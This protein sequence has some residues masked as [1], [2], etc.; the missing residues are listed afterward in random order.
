MLRKAAFVLSVVYA[1]K[2]IIR[3]FLINASLTIFPVFERTLLRLLRR[4]YLGKGAAWRCLGTLKPRCP[5]AVRDG[6]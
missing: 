5:S 3:V 6:S 2:D 1:Q 4:S